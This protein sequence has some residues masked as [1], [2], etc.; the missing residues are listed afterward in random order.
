MSMKKTIGTALAATLLI[1]GGYVFLQGNSSTETLTA[2]FADA[3]P[4]EVG[5]EVRVDGVRVGA[6]KSISLDGKVAQVALS[7]EKSALPLHQDAR[8]TIRPINVLG[9]NYVAIDPGSASSPYMAGS[10]IPLNQTS[11]S[12]QLQD[13][14]DTF[15]N[16]T[17]TAL[18]SMITTLGEGTRDGGANVADAIKA[19]A[20]TM[21]DLNGLGQI[22][23]E[24]NQVLND[25][26]DRADPVARSVAGDNGKQLDNLVTQV[27]ETLQALGDNQQ[28]IED[29]VAQ[30]PA[31]LAEARTTLDNLTAVSSSVTPTL[32]RARPL[33]SQLSTIS[34]EITNFSKYADPAFNGFGP[35]FAEANKLLRQAAPVATALRVAGPHLQRTAA[36]TRPVG[37][38]LLHDHLSDLMSFVTKWALSTNSRDGASHY[39]RGVV[40]V[41]PKDLLTLLG[42]PLPKGT[43]GGTSKGKGIGEVVGGLAS[44]VSGLIGKLNGLLGGVLGGASQNKTSA[45]PGTDGATGLTQNQEQGLLGQ[46]LGGL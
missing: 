20:P 1:G 18:A 25:L 35:L 16:P 30:L 32:K 6:I 17:S 45:A 13:V 12:V 9:E 40:Y 46:L 14:L 27:R 26:V 4:L 10:A 34:G 5:N 44:P 38:I 29:T 43:L 33:T 3:S 11:S 42:G 22:L 7:L 21:N 37:K 41:T 19:L 39:F 15:N 23:R 28:A 2:T 31:T 24:Q 8:L 36:Q